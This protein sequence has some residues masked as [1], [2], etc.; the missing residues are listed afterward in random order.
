MSYVSYSAFRYPQEQKRKKEAADRHAA[1]EAG[2]SGSRRSASATA[3]G[4]ADGDGY[5]D[6]GDT[7]E[8]DDGDDDE[9]EVDEIVLHDCD[10]YGD[11]NSSRQVLA[12]QVAEDDVSSV[13]ILSADPRQHAGMMHQQGQQQYSGRDFD[14]PAAVYVPDSCSSQGL[15]LQVGSANYTNDRQQDPAPR[16]S[17]MRTDRPLDLS[18]L[19]GM[20]TEP[21]SQLDPEL[22]ARLQAIQQLSS[23]MG[24]SHP[25]VRFSMKY[26]SRLLFSRGDF[27]GAQVLQDYIHDAH[28]KQRPNN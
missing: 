28:N 26:T 14:F 5:E 7:D 13:S 18:S 23:M 25:D 20:V 11:S 2:A 21:I 6:T 15:G 10:C 12:A 3:T 24:P 9:E 16:Q 1:Q 4:T 27:L 17:V 8:K 22:R 19:E